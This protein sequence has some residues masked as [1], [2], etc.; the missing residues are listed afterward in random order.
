LN[1]QSVSGK[2]NDLSAFGCD[3]SHTQHLKLQV[4]AGHINIWLNEQLI[5]N[6]LLGNPDFG[7][8][9]G[10]R[11]KFLGN[12]EVDFVRLAN[13]KNELLLDEDF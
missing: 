6:T 5:F 10:V 9:V 11:Y 1:G 8:I 7:A 12:G 4:E 2:D 13:H 3:F